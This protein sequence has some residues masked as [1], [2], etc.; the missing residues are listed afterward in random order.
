[1]D[2]HVSNE[3]WEQLEENLALSIGKLV[4]AFSQME[5]NFELI[6]GV[7]AGNAPDAPN[8]LKIR[9]MSFNDKLKMIDKLMKNNYALDRERTELFQ[10]WYEHADEVRKKRNAYIHGRWGVLPV[11]RCAENISY[12]SDSKRSTIARRLTLADLENELSEAEGL[13]PAFHALLG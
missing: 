7:H 8:A 12:G 4:L 2:R 10:R 1:M 9:K 5:F 6:I 3:G 11:E 13:I